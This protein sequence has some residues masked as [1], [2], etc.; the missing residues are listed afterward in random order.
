MSAQNRNYRR[1]LLNRELSVLPTFRP[2]TDCQIFLVN[3]SICPMLVQDLIQLARQTTRF[4]IDTERDYVTHDPA[5]LQIEFIHV[6]SVVLLVEACHL[7]HS[8]S[9]L[10]WLI[11]SLLKII[12]SPSNV[13]FCWGDLVFEL[14]AFVDYGLV[15]QHVI[16]QL[17]TTDVQYE[18]KQWYNQRFPHTCGLPPLHND[19]PV[20]TCLHRPVKHA[21]DQWSLQRA[22][23]YTFYEFLD[24]TRTNSKWSYSLGRGNNFYQYSLIA[25]KQAKKIYEHLILYAVNDCLAVTKLM[26]TVNLGHITK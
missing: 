8:S 19:N 1:S 9:V 12:F 21:S 5:L 13:L 11:R 16:D 20:C 18:F 23:A 17:T 14:N 2:F 22:I 7:P 4:V 6:K 3:H 26:M 10:F 15:S 24:K 25:S